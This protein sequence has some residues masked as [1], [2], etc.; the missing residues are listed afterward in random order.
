MPL[1]LFKEWVVTIVK[2]SR[3]D[4]VLNNIIFIIIILLCYGQSLQT[5]THLSAILW[6]NAARPTYTMLNSFH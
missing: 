4:Q 6:H 5:P 3:V 2:D 1:I